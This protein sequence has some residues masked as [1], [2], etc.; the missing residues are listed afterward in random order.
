MDC[1][2]VN[3]V[4]SELKPANTFKEAVAECLGETAVHEM[5]RE[6]QPER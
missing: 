3:Y 2:F 6:R 1:Y 4:P 5:E